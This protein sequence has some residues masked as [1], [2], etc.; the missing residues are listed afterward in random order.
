MAEA[1][2]DAENPERLE[3]EE[4]TAIQPGLARLMPEISTR[5]WKAWY[6]AQARN[7]PLASWQLREMRKL[8]RLG[9]VTR[10][11]YHDDLEES[12]AEDVEPLLAALEEEDLG[13][14][15]RIYHEAADAANE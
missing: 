13:R 6:A 14:F 15:E 8:L 12:I 3:L 9:E 10:P 11:K 4:L 5:F 2:H 7:W 1:S